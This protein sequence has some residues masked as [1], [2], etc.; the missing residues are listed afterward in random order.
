MLLLVLL[1]HMVNILVTKLRVR[2][3]LGGGIATLL[4]YL[5]GDQEKFSKITFVTFAPVA[6]LV[7]ELAAPDHG[8]ITSVINETDLVPTFSIAA[9]DD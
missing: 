7:G 1:K 5:L 9:F 6:S 2:H 8:F 4:T 3:S